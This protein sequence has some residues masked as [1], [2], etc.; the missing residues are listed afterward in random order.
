MNNEIE[1]S[2]LNLRY[3]G[4]RLRQASVEKGLLCDIRE[5]GITD[6]LEGVGNYIL[7]NGFKRYRC[8]QAL[9]LST[10]P[11]IKIGEDEVMGL[12]SLLRVSKDKSLN[13]LEQAALI[14]E[15]KNTHGQT[16]AEIADSLSRSKA[17]V[18]MRSGLISEMSPHIKQLL[19]EGKFP[20]YSYMYNLRQFMRMNGVSVEDIEQFMV[21]LSGKALSM[22]EIELL[23]H[24][25]FRGPE[26]LRRE[27]KNGHVLVILPRMKEISKNSDACTK[28]E[29]TLL[30]DL[31][32][33]LKC[34]LRIMTKSKDPR[35]GSQSFRAQ[36]HL[37]S[38]ELLSRIAAITPILHELYDRS[39]QA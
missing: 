17:W 12:T 31:E 38:A 23:A 13:I 29:R 28:F 9:K 6:P 5:R 10:V 19:F 37:L 18:S 30:R 39:E 34:L 8:A 33:G 3:A 24:G 22:R 14:D 26:S 20:V 25:F 35:L 1:L 32:L 15:L 11:Y 21:A 27:I 16:I 2:L 4:Y 7:L 36:C